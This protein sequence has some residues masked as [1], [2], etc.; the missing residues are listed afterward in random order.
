MTSMEECQ[1]T[2]SK[3]AVVSFDIQK[4]FDSVAHWKLLEHL[5]QSFPLTLNARRWIQAFLAER[6]QRVRVGTSLS[7]LSVITS[8]VPQGTVLGP[9]LYNAATAG[10][11]DL[12]LSEGSHTVQYADDM[13][14]CIDQTSVMCRRRG[15]PLTRLRCHCEVLSGRVS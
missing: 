12:R 14:K 10:I 5:R 6:T 15:K 3:V 1:G 11:K 9:I 7:E 13:L 2:S 4:A 8:G